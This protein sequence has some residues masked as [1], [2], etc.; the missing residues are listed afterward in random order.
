MVLLSR[1]SIALCFLFILSGCGGG[2]SGDEGSDSSGRVASSSVGQEAGGSAAD[3]DQES[4][5]DP[6]PQESA[7]PPEETPVEM[8]MESGP[9]ARMITKVRV[10]P[11]DARS[12]AAS[13]TFGQ[14]FAKGDVPA[15]GRVVASLGN[16]SVPIQ[17]DEKATWKDGSLRHAII[18]I[19]L[20]ADAVGDGATVLIGTTDEAPSDTA[21]KTPA[22]S[23]KDL[24]GTTFEASAA[25]TAGGQTVRLS[26]RDALSAFA[27]S[28]DCPA[29]GQANC[30]RWLSGP[31]VSEWIVA[32]LPAKMPAAA[33][34]LRVYFHVRA[35]SNGRGGVGNVRVD[36]VL[37]NSLT[38][39]E[40]PHN[41]VYSARLN[42][43][44]QSYSVDNLT[45]YRQAR[46]HRVLWFDKAGPALAAHLDTDYL[47]QARAV[48]RYAD[49]SPTKKF[50]D[51]VSKEFRP[52]TRG[53]QTLRMGNAGA[54]PGI[55]PLPRWTSAYVVS[56]DERALKWM[57][58]NDDAVGSYSIHYRDAATGRPL[59]V[60]DHPYVTLIA[61]PHAVR[62]GGDYTRD[63]L[64][65]CSGS[66]ANPH[67]FD[68]A[69]HPSIGYVSYL[70]TGDY[71]YLEE[72]Q[73]T[74]SYIQIWANPKY[75]DFDKGGL[76]DAQGQVRA[77]AWSMRSISDAAFATPDNDPTK[78]SLVKHI[79]YIVDE[80]RRTYV[81]NDADNP[82][83][84]IDNYG[85]VIYS[86]G[87]QKRSAIGPWQADFFT[88]A[89]GH[90][91][92]Q[93]VA[94]ASDLLRWLAVFPIGRMTEWRADT[95]SNYCWLVASTYALQIRASQGGANYS[96]LNTAY[97]A[98][99]PNL[100]GL[101]CDGRP[102]LNE[103]SEIRQTRF[104]TG[105]M[106]GYAKSPTG[107][108]SN[109]QI[110]LAMA[111]DSG[112]PH[113]AQAWSIFSAR[114]FSP[115]YA[116]YSNYAVIPRSVGR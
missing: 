76:I 94:G 112:A 49:V 64:P 34:N 8:P 77:Q 67:E 9:P 39:S 38:Y 105:Q 110:G 84:V 104:E 81:E 55:G 59:S 113:G 87:G 27:D 48:S 83:H 7:E 28:A 25:V 108:P 18:T 20:G 30:K 51:G 96:D 36:T 65:T 57:L 109:L 29:W 26:A 42:T 23:V 6:D 15:G 72:M 102:M 91:K 98:T 13:T 68:I 90:L 37:E 19:R 82:L 114:E 35:Y 86:V 2:S 71:Y 101:E 17:V 100:V 4:D 79:D 46:W 53:D 45:H 10:T 58:A 61:R 11:T 74:A 41:L 92:E 32:A 99:H 106:I 107:F 56:G 97:A 21:I 63:L 14:A 78:A 1:L 12:Q 40:Q 54:Q 24:L 116:N 69:H 89:M 62:A 73:F 22:V 103:L 60:R 70:V 47:Q 66:C 111:A 52:M 31:L 95:D 33:D 115:D 50:L 44:N 43:G 5:P 85:A 80:Y 16:R 3:V 93:D 75:R 88:W